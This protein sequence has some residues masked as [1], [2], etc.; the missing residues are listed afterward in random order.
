MMDLFNLRVVYFDPII[1]SIDCTRIDIEGKYLYL[2]KVWDHKEQ[3]F[4]RI[5]DV[6]DV[7][8]LSGFNF[9]QI[10]LSAA[11]KDRICLNKWDVVLVFV[12]SD[13]LGLFVLNVNIDLN[14]FAPVKVIK[15]DKQCVDLV[16]MYS[17][18]SSIVVK[19]NL[20][21]L[22]D[23]SINQYSIHVDPFVYI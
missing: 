17:I 21:Y 1:S 22:L 23:L 14:D 15:V 8:L 4:S 13:Q 20:K 18:V 19:I 16:D 7:D 9:V 11:G 10:K 2:L 5:S 6:L 12:I 3:I